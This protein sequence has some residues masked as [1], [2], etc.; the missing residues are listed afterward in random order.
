MLLATADGVVRYAGWSGNFGLAVG[1]VAGA[2]SIL[3]AWYGVN[4][5][6][7]GGRHAYGSGSG[8]LVPVLAIVAAN[9][10]FM[11]FAAFRYVLETRT[12]VLLPP[13]EADASPE[14]S[15]GRVAEA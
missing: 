2:T 15:G 11:G 3:M 8:G 14:S 1:S 10:I 7:P 13:D 4:Y 9:W 12:P 5:V 6:F